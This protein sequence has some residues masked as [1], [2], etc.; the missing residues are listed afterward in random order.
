[1]I[2][3]KHIETRVLLVF[4]KANGLGGFFMQFDIIQISIVP[5]MQ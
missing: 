2:G 5:G 1:M 4:F 3:V